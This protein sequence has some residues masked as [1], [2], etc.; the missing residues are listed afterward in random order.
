MIKQAKLEDIGVNKFQQDDLEIQ[1]KG[2]D[3]FRT[4]I[5]NDFGGM[6]TND[7]FEDDMVKANVKNFQNGGKYNYLCMNLNKFLKF[8]FQREGKRKLSLKY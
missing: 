7:F 4:M 8:N 2:S 1:K 3:M 6:R 5:G